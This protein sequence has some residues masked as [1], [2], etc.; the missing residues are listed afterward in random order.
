MFYQTVFSPQVKRCAITTYKHGIHEL[1]QELPNGLR[2]T[3]S[4][5]YEISRKS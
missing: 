3:I 4:G 2:L 5:N 1:P